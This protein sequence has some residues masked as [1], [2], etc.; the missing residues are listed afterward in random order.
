MES[1][2]VNMCAIVIFL[3]CFIMDKKYIY[4]LFICVIFMKELKMMFKDSWHVLTP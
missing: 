4:I 1:D 2:T 3:F